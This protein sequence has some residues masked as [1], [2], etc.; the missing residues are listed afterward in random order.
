MRHLPHMK[1][2]FRV[3]PLRLA[4]LNYLIWKSSARLR[5]NEG[6]GRSVFLGRFRWPVLVGRSALN[7]QDTAFS[8]GHLLFGTAYLWYRPA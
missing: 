4:P 3:L 5:S 8:V 2:R 6:G 1:S 7:D